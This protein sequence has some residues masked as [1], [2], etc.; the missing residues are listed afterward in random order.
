M[1]ASIFRP[2]GL[3]T[4]P[5]LE[6][7]YINAHIDNYIKGMHD[8]KEYQT[9]EL[10]EN[11]FNK[12]ILQ[13][14]E[15][16]FVN[17]QQPPGIKSNKSCDIVIKYVE[18]GTF[19]TKILCFVECKRSKKTTEY[20]LRKV[21]QQALDYC[22][23]YL[24]S[25]GDLPFVFACTACGAH[26]RLWKYSQ[27][28]DNFQGFWGGFSLA[29]WE[30]YKDVGIDADAVEIRQALEHMLVTGPELREGQ[31]FSAY[32]SVQEGKGKQTADSQAQ[33]PV[34][35]VGQ[36]AQLVVATSYESNGN[37]AVAFALNGEQKRTW[38]SD[39]SRGQSQNGRPLCYH[40]GFNVYYE[41]DEFKRG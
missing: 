11:I 14:R 7:Q 8:P 32:A 28:D 23:E 2:H 24:E 25:D 10:L 6:V 39:W 13:E 29:S 5:A 19:F 4:T 33:I 21:E 40:K 41:Y 30:N 15:D 22:K 27:G 12:V 38:L 26:L 9:V 31:D 34:P 37:T 17:S 20:D 3:I 36:A 1:A 18:S 16:I 35:G